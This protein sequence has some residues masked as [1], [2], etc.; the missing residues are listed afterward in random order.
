MRLVD[1]LIF[2]TNILRVFHEYHPLN[3]Q[4]QVGEAQCS[5]VH[6]YYIKL[7]GRA[8]PVIPP[9]INIKAWGPRV[10]IK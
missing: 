8:Q 7:L 9:I 2:E 1:G 3:S 10:N 4:L 5:V 6:K